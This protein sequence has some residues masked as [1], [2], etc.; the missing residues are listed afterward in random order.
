MNVC[1]FGVSAYVYRG[2]CIGWLA[3]QPQEAHPFLPYY[4]SV[5]VKTVND[6]GNLEKHF[7]RLMVSE[8][9]SPWGQNKG[10][11]ATTAESSLDAQGEEE[12]RVGV[13]PSFETSEHTSSNS[14]YPRRT[15]LLILPK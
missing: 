9:Y 1:I 7:I 8:G 15:Y 13:A 2:V 3:S 14:P 5:P 6:Q 11:V 4:S 10:M 12:N